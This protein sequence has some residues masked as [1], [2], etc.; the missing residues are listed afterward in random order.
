MTLELA[1]MHG[2]LLY[3]VASTCRLKGLLMYTSIGCNT[4]VIP[5]GMTTSSVFVL[6]S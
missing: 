6:W 4:D 1:D 5:A 3:I 2:E